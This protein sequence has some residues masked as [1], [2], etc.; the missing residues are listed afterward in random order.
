MRLKNYKEFND[1]ENRTV[2]FKFLS[3]DNFELYTGY[4]EKTQYENIIS[5]STQIGCRTQCLLFCNVEEFK[6]DITVD[7]VKFQ[8]DTVM[9]K[10]KIKN[11]S[12]VKISMVKEGEPLDNKNIV[13]IVNEIA[14]LDYKYLKLSTSMPSDKKEKL[15][16][17]FSQNF[18]NDMEIQVQV[19]L[20]ST[21]DTFRNKYVRRR[22]MTLEE[23]RDV[24][25]EI[26]N[27][28]IVN[29]KKYNYITLSF[30]LYEESE[31]STDVIAKIFDPKIFCIRIRDASN[32]K[33][34]GQKYL[35][36]TDETFNRYKKDIEEKGFC[37]VDGRSAKIAVDN[38]LTMGLF[39]L[40]EV[41][42]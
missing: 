2:Q 38:N 19:S 1:E 16:Q 6:R 33:T 28:S 3:E 13:D 9:E 10:L 37:F 30:T 31:F 42:V 41:L 23:I 36:I 7:E 24:C 40:K 22:L 18:K 17:V 32:S 11:R 15:I 21:N 14:N 35:R 25:K 34:R 39:Q 29:N 8:I 27:L 20:S 26:Y 4:W 5:I 12:N